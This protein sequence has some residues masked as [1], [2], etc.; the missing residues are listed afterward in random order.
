MNTCNIGEKERDPNGNS[1][2]REIGIL[3]LD[4]LILVTFITLGNLSKFAKPQ[5]PLVQLGKL[6]LPCRALERI[7]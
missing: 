7:K 2:M 6:S 5:L 3:I 4:L 1:E